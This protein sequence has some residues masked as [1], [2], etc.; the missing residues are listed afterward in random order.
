MYFP[1]IESAKCKNHGDCFKIS[2]EDAFDFDSEDVGGA[3]SEDCTK[4]EACVVVCPEQAFWI[5]E[6]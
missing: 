5:E 2:P 1:K 4:Y 6:M 3:R